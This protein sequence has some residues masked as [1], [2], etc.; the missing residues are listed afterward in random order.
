[1]FD[2]FRAFGDQSRAKY[3]LFLTR[4]CTREQM[5]TLVSSTGPRP[6]S[7]QFWPR[8]GVASISQQISKLARQEAKQEARTT[9]HKQQPEA[10]R[11]TIPGINS[12]VDYST[13]KL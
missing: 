1:L 10:Q 5:R 11:T 6:L 4:E 9:N 13:S 8:G 7:C 3:V 2:F 12:N